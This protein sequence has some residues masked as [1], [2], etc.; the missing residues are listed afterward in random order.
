MKFKRWFLDNYAWAPLLAVLYAS[1]VYATMQSGSMDALAAST[2]N[3]IGG[4]IFVVML[5]GC[6]P[7]FLPPRSGRGKTK[8]SS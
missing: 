2:K 4:S 6:I 5:L 1:V 8:K 3:L 7:L